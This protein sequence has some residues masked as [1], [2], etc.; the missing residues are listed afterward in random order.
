MVDAS[1]CTRTGFHIH[2]FLEGKSIKEKADKKD[3][4]KKR[5]KMA[6]IYASERG[7]LV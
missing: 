3:L 1:N 2:R 4:F 7:F 6:L 5:L